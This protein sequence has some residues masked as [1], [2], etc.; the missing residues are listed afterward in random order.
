[1]LHFWY[2]V[3]DV[4]FDEFLPFY[5]LSDIPGVTELPRRPDAYSESILVPG[6]MVFGDLVVAKMFVSE[7]AD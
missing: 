5:D 1:M 2:L 6:G 7:H 3:P 4:I